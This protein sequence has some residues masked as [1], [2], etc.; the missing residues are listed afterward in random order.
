MIRSLI[1]V[2]IAVI[3][4]FALAKMVESAGA[5][6]TGA[7]PGSAAYGSM[8]LLGWLLG[9]FLAAL[10]ALIFGGKW[11]PLGVLGAASIFLGAVITL[12]SYP[13]NWLLWPGALLATAL[14]GLGAVKLTGAG[15][16]H[17]AQRKSGL[18]DD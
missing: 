9:A 11:A 12:F 4:G 7:A 16:Q 13:L 1:S 5:S 14:G 3:A 8:L 2:I 17:P 18:F 10:V 15:F 6:V